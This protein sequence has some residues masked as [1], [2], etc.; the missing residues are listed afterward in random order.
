MMTTMTHRQRLLAVMD[1]QRP[2]RVPWIP[3][4]LLWYTAQVNRGTMPE[5]YAGL[6]LRELEKQLCMGTP[7]RD[8][9]VFRT[10]QG[11]DVEIREHQQG[12]SV[13]TE[14]RTPVG[15]VTTRQ[16]SS[17]VLADAGIQALEVEHMIKEPADIDVVAYLIENQSYE[18]T[19]DEYLA[20][21]AQIGDDGYPLVQVGD[22]PFHHFLQKQAGYQNAFY[23]LADCPEKVEAHLRRMEEIER[24]RVWPL[25][26]SSPARLLLHG[27]HFDSNLTPPPLF[28]RYITPYYQDL[29]AQL[30]HCGKTLCTH[31]DND[32]RLILGHMRDA[33]FDMAETFTT[34]PQVSCTLQQAR[35]AWGSNV[36]I[37][38][39]IPSV[40]LEPTFSEADFE[41]YMAGVFTTIAPG[42]AFILGVADNV[43]PDAL[44]SRLERI[45]DMVEAWGD[46]PIN[47]ALVKAPVLV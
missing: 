47:P 26:V 17:S 16:R 43:M 28:E 6:T 31:A 25:L 4:L 41:Q 19:Y 11:G 12:D 37:W 21:E 3:R 18:A 34:E 44:I 22:V 42:D 7:A 1:H 33:G 30:H 9:H 2:D 20:Y 23:L 35:D 45:S 29:S 32:S 36:I 5:R 14:T 38:G 24:E 46:L 8:G 27:L 15:T 13:L 40:I 10:H 39:G